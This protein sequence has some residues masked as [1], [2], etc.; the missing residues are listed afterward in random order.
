MLKIFILI[1]TAG[2]VLYIASAIL[3][4]IDEIV[5]LK[6]KKFNSDKIIDR[7]MEENKRFSK[8]CKPFQYVFV[9]C[10]IIGGIGCFLIMGYN[11]LIMQPTI[12]SKLSLI[13]MMIILLL[14]F[15]ILILEQLYITK[16]IF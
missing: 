8:N 9:I 13:F 11:G 10:E 6:S 2:L 12:A 3:V 5:A 7:Y 4:K 14:L 16:E 1:F 15:A